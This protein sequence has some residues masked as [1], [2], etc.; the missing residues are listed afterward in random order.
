MATPG[1]Q[2]FNEPRQKKVG[3]GVTREG[4]S[5]PPGWVFNL[6]SEAPRLTPAYPHEGKKG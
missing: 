5:P 6:R 4:E 2:Y 3:V 1:L